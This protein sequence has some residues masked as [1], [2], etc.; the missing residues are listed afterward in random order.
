MMEEVQLIG[1]PGI[2]VAETSAARQMHYARTKSVGV[3]DGSRVDSPAEDQTGKDLG[4]CP[5]AMRELDAE[6]T[7]L[8]GKWDHHEAEEVVR[9]DQA[10]GRPSEAVS[11][12]DHQ[13]ECFVKAATAED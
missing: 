9:S 2:A 10:E 3:G 7:E 1:S 12:A 4:R 5:V 6:G 8:N 11:D 13:R